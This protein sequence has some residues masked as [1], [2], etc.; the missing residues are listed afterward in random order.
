M[1]VSIS[2]CFIVKECLPWWGRGGWCG[3]SLWWLVL[4]AAG[5]PP[6]SPGFYSDS[7]TSTSP[8]CN[9]NT[10]HILEFKRISESQHTMNKMSRPVLD[11]SSAGGQSHGDVLPGF[12]VLPSTR[13][14]AAQLSPALLK[15][16]LPLILRTHTQTPQ[17]PVISQKYITREVNEW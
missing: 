4:R 14:L 6:D 17:L 3:I 11:V 13:C 7:E 5:W 16:R 2:E 9:T 10:K 1:N 8:D 15:H 12:Q